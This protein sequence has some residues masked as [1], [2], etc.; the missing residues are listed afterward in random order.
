VPHRSR[1]PRFYH[2]RARRATTLLFRVSRQ[3]ILCTTDDHPNIGPRLQP[4]KKC[5]LLVLSSISNSHVCVY[6]GSLGKPSSLDPI[7][8][9][10]HASR[11]TRIVLLP[12]VSNFTSDLACKMGCFSPQEAVTVLD[13]GRIPTNTD[14][15]KIWMTNSARA[16]KAALRFS[17]TPQGVDARASEFDKRD[18][19]F[20]GPNPHHLVSTMS[21]NLPE[22]LPEIPLL[23]CLWLNDPLFPKYR[24]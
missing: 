10:S 7:R 19:N 22:N 5:S 16:S 23:P 15:A 6:L 9:G 24:G 21:G 11:G 17:E 13:E 18:E 12:K 2:I 20:R 1:A 8:A 3:A 4:S 14:R